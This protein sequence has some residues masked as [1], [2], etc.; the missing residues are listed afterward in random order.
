[1]RISYIKS[2]ND[3]ESFRIPQFLGS[4]VVELDNVEKV[5]ESIDNLIGLKYNTIVLSNE[6][7]GFSESIMK[8]YYNSKKINIII[9][10]SKRI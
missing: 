6:V 1:M 4:K 10:P 7:A 2:K 9:A 3:L 5:D 8:K